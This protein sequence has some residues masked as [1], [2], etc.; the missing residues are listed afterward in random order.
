MLVLAAGCALARSAPDSA[1]VAAPEMTLRDRLR[2]LADEIWDSEL[3]Y[4]PTYATLLGLPGARHD[5]LYDNSGR[6][7]AGLNDAWWARLQ[8]LPADSFLHTSDAVLFAI[9][10][11]TL[12]SDREEE[13]VCRRGFMPISQLFGWQVRFA[14]LARIQPVGT[15]EARAQALARWSELPAYLDRERANLRDGVKHGYV[16]PIE[17]VRAVI[18]QLDRVL[19]LPPDSSPFADPARR[20]S[21]PDFRV[22]WNRLITRTITPA[23]RKYREYLATK[24]L[25][26]A[27]TTIG[28]SA[29]PK[30]VECYRALVRTYTTLDRDPKAVHELGLREVERIEGEMRTLA[31]R[32]F[33]TS[34]V[35]AL[36][37]RLRTDPQYSFRSRDEMREVAERALA[38][39]KAAAPRMFAR[40]PKADVIV[41]P[42]Q[43]FEE[44][45]GCPGF[46]E[47]PAVDG[48]HPARYRINLHDP[49]GTPR[50]GAEA[51]A[52]HEMIP[53]H[54]LQL[55]LALE[56]DSVLPLKR[57]YRNSGYMEGWALYA[58]Q[59]A[60]ELG[61]YSSDL[62][63][64]GRLSQDALRA[65]RL[66]V[67]PG[68]H[69]LGWSR[70]Q[71]IDYLLAHTALSEWQATLEVDRYIVE[72]GQATAYMIGRLEI[73][74]LRGLAAAQLGSRFDLREF[75]QVVLEDGVV[76]LPFLSEKIERWIASRR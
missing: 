9:V 17:N 18:A 76:P 31:E 34:D 25:P 1:P 67:D 15:P 59:L 69:V 56:R 73:E 2:A 20:D 61:L 72:P 64:L 74:R 37:V 5:R 10:Q 21:T 50:A 52:F 26:R 8:A 23:V 55:A 58:E 48:S 28:L 12:A 7:W 46:Y 44:P 60:H 70:R 54:H 53:G 24:Y 49:H 51:T 40:I 4:W 63:E 39:A 3:A 75:H 71:A 65:A 35:R 14:Y 27:R 29:L 30:G 6:S 68:I 42:C 19:A 47:V 38:R 11:E 62:A 45:S 32:R 22:A 33:G 16:V 41:D 57:F 43:P 13:R 66:V 36:L